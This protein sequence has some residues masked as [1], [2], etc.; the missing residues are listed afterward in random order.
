[1]ARYFW[2]TNFTGE[3]FFLEVFCMQQK[4]KPCKIFTRLFETVGGERD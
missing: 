2:L 3:L 4:G 1:L